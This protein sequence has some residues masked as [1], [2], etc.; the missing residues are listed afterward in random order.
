MLSLKTIAWDDSRKVF[1]SPIHSEFVWDLKEPTFAMCERCASEGTIGLNCTCG[2]YH[3]PNI[4]SLDEYES[5][6]TSII[7]WI[8]LF[9]RTDIWSGPEPDLTWTYP[10]RSDGARIIGIVGSGSLHS[11]GFLKGT[12]GITEGLACQ[13][14]GVPLRP[15]GY[16]RQV[17]REAWIK[18]FKLDP[19]QDRRAK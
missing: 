7:A 5:F 4:E 6:P 1:C 18:Y 19:Y 13:M 12:R 9:G 15:W 11:L 14:F 2:V 16:V 10:T 17:T 8:Q 3:S